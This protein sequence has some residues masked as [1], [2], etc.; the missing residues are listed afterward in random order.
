MVNDD[1]GSNSRPRSNFHTALYMR[2]PV[3][4]S[5]ILRNV[6]EFTRYIFEHGSPRV[7]I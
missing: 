5:E 2:L 4:L 1:S 6:Q 7:A 3:L